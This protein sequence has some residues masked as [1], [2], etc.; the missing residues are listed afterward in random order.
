[1]HDSASLA[2]G[3][4]LGAGATL[5][6]VCALGR[7]QPHPSPP[8]EIADG[9]LGL[10]GNTPLVR[11]RSLS[12]ATGCEILAKAE[13]LNP[14]GSIKDRVAKSILQRAIATSGLP[15]GGLIAEGTSGSTGVSLALVAAALGRRA[16]VALPS[17]AAAE[18]AATLR[19]LGAEV[20][21]VPP[22]G[23]SHPEHFV[24][25]A[26][27]M[28][29]EAGGAFADQFETGANWRTH[30]ETTAEEIWQQAGGRVDAFVSGSGTGGTI[31]GVGRRLKE[32]SEDVKVV[33]VDPPGSGLF[34]K[35]TRGVMYAPEEAEGQRRRNP[36]DIITEGVGLNR[37][38]AN[39]AQASIDAAFQCSDREAVEMAA[40]LVR[41]DGLWVGSSSAL[42]CVGAVKAAR[43]LRAQA[44]PE[45]R[46]PVVVTVLC[47]GGHRHL[48]KFYS[49]GVLREAGLVP[50]ETGAS[51]AFVS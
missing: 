51:L 20:A 11:I 38:T 28:A 9:L 50:R 17:D 3:A 37:L 42:N 32:L 2:V 46:R 31:A 10:I 25:V 23:I 12:E 41:N 35:V 16:F 40:Y 34:A 18:K 13:F 19:A 39:F 48:S 5:C 43:R 21:E 15:P 8:S 33:L 27:R 7:W 29:D 22:V 36:N 24:H 14:G 4:V 49:P 47:D 44:G 1:M 45:G 26:R 6:A 30:Y